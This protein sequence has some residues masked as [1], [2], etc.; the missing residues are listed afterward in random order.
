MPFPNGSSNF[1]VSKGKR[2]PVM[3]SIA[4]NRRPEKREDGKLAGG[5]LEE[6]FRA[7]FNNRMSILLMMIEHPEISR[8]VLSVERQR[9]FLSDL[10]HHFL[11]PRCDLKYR[12]AFEWLFRFLEAYPDVAPRRIYRAIGMVGWVYEAFGLELPNRLEAARLNREGISEKTGGKNEDQT[13]M[14]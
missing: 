8:H 13:E 12:H 11:P 2:D 9:F 5:G 6:L 1:W 3:K 14:G 4:R 7:Y 10:Y